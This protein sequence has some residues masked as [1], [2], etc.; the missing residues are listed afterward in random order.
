M[1]V[2][3]LVLSEDDIDVLS[4][5]ALNGLVKCSTDLV[6]TKILSYLDNP[7]SRESTR[8]RI[9]NAYAQSMNRHVFLNDE[10]TKGMVES[11]NSLTCLDITAE[12]DTALLSKYVDAIDGIL[13]NDLSTPYIE[14]KTRSDYDDFLLAVS[15]DINNAEDD[16]VRSRLQNI[17]KKMDAYKRIFYEP[18]HTPFKGTVVKQVMRN[19][20]NYELISRGAKFLLDKRSKGESP[21]SWRYL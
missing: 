5:N 17:S 15:D 6:M 20:Q 11:I 3:P 21:A 1:D 4:D 9:R 13:N 10:G 19:R 18:K 8:E 12:T 14:P 7:N 2:L 16:V